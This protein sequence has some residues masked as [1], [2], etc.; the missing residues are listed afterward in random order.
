MGLHAY[1]LQR[2]LQ[3]EGSDVAVT[4]VAPGLVSTEIFSNQRGDP[5]AYRHAPRVLQEKA[6][7]P[8]MGAITTV[9]AVMAVPAVPVERWCV[10][11]WTPPCYGCLPKGAI[12]EIEKFLELN[13]RCTWG[14]YV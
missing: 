3:A 11:Y 6:V 1:E 4:P 7:T 9:H 14:V 12:W 2:K 13:Q 8:S 10:P 5:K